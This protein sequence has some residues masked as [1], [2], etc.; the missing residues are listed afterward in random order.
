M[1]RKS[2][3]TTACKGA[4]GLMAS[5]FLLS[6]LGE[7]CKTPAGVVRTRSANGLVKIPLAE[8]TASAYKL[9]RVSDYNY[10]LAIQKNDDGSYTI[11]VLKCSHAAQPLTRTGANYYCT[12]HG[13]QFNHEGK[14][15]KGPAEHD[16]HRLRSATDATDLVIKLD[17]SI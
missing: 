15:L 13:S 7:S 8:F 17:Y 6:V 12:L 5:G 1:D 3:L 10:D 16:L 14:V 4:C 11:L 2:F 9:V